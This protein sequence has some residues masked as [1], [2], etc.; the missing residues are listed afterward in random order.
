MNQDALSFLT[1]PWF[2]QHALVGV[3]AGYGFRVFEH[4]VWASKAPPHQNP[5]GNVGFALMVLPQSVLFGFALGY[6]LLAIV[7]YLIPSPTVAEVCAYGIPALM[8][9]LAADLRE[10]MR[11]VSRI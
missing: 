6:L 9:F 2:L 10:L 8:A 5:Q 1:Q 11:R 3:A 7:A 4:I